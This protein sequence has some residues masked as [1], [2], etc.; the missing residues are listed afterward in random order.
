MTSL[1]YMTSLT[2]HLP[3]AILAASLAAAVGCGSDSTGPGG[4]RP[5]RGVVVLNTFGVRGV[6]LL[7]DTGSESAHIDF[8]DG[9]DGGSFTLRN[10]TLLSTSSSLGGD[11]LYVADLE[12]TLETFQMPPGSNPAGAAFLDG[13]STYLVALRN[14]GQLAAVARTLESEANITLFDNMGRCPAD[15]FRYGGDLYAVDANAS[16]AEGTYISQGPARL[17]RAATSGAARDT[18]PLP[19]SFGTGASVVVDGDFA[20]VALN[21]VADFSDYPVTTFVTPG[22]VTKVNLVTRQAVITV[23][24]APG[25]YGAGM[26]RGAD[27]L[28]YVALFTSTDFSTR[29]I[30]RITPSTMDIE[31]ALPLRSATGAPAN[32]VAATADAQGRVHCVVTDDGGASTL[33]VFDGS[34]TATR[35]VP[36]GTYAADLAVR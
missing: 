21:G 36:A 9:F 19:V 30:H 11:K 12:G 22:S 28:L 20:Y 33:L 26:R 6:T 27:G 13:T 5:S 8:G 4:A 29:V 15:V 10:D 16:C 32:C 14:T 17:I 7:A 24:F 25:T 34:G 2:R 35:S 1:A 3:A 23:Q 31:S 18:I